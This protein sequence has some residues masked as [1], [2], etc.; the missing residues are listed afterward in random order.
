MNDVTYTITE[1]QVVRLFC[2][3]PETAYDI[4]E[5][6]YAFLL[7]FAKWNDANGDFDGMEDADLRA[8]ISDWAQDV[9]G[10]H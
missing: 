7:A 3:R 1:G 8:M 2:E 5:A 9:Y 10:E 4:A 6:P